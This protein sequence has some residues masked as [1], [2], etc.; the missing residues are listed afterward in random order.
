MCAV[1]SLDEKL[2]YEELLAL[3]SFRCSSKIV[4][5]LTVDAFQKP[6]AKPIGLASDKA[7]KTYWVYSN[8]SILEIPVRREDRDVWKIYLQRSEH[9]LALQYAKVSHIFKYIS[10]RY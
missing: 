6:S 4:V 3:V 1:S 10:K 9:A 5:Q 2:V 7:N 8:T